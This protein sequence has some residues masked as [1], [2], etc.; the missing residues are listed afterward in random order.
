MSAEQQDS[1]IVLFS[2][3]TNYS[4]IDFALHTD[5]TVKYVRGLPHVVVPLPSRNEKCQFTLRPVSHNVGDFLDM[6]RA[7]DKGID[8]ATIVNGDGHRI[9]AACS[10]EHLMD[11]A[12]WY[13]S[14]VYIS[15][16][17]FICRIRN[18]KNWVTTCN[19]GG[20]KHSEI[21][22]SEPLHVSGQWRIH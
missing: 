20:V 1:I 16:K 10:I 22:R 19:K 4:G 13:V 3:F 6:L 2:S 15:D 17:L 14:I 18:S 7:E 11:E 5:V 12:F 8:R 9:A 21:M